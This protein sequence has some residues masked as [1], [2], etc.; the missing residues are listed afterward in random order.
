MNPVTTVNFDV[1]NPPVSPVIATTLYSGPPLTVCGNPVLSLKASGI[2][3]NFLT[4]TFD[5]TSG[6]ISIK[7]NDPAAAVKGTYSVDAVFVS[8]GA[9]SWPLG[10][11][12]TVYDICD[13]S[14]FPSAPEITPVTSDYQI[15][16]GDL[17]VQVTWA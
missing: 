16:E 4:A 10:L 6:L 3:L 7:L 5:A 11:V 2:A 17:L 14:T 13:T 15:G 9:Y 8:P 1:R 12:L